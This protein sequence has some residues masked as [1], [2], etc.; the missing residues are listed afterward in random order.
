[1]SNIANMHSQN[2]KI[3]KWKLFMHIHILK[4]AEIRTEKT[5]PEKM[6]RERR[7]VEE[8]KKRTK[9]AIPAPPLERSRLLK[10]QHS[11]L[12]NFLY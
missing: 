11:D 5:L 2:K 7:K 12:R 9:L 8:K 10:M 1:M 6:V 3:I 4:V